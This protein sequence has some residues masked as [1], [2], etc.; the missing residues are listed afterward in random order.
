MPKLR[1]EDYWPR[2]SIASSSSA[3]RRVIMVGDHLDS[4]APAPIQLT[5]DRGRGNF[6]N[7]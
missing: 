2:S 5:E 4:L 7:G 1:R 3:A 6:S